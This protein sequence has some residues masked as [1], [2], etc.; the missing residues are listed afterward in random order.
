MTWRHYSI[1]P[2]RRV[3]PKNPTGWAVTD[4]QMTAGVPAALGNRQQPGEHPPGPAPLL[5]PKDE[6]GIGHL[7]ARLLSKGCVHI[8]GRHRARRQRKRRVEK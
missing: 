7:S 5:H 2:T 3:K 4:S 8:K 6:K 1:R